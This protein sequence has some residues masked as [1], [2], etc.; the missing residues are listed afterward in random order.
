MRLFFAIPISDDAKNLI[1][2]SIREEAK[3]FN[4]K[5]VKKENLH[6]TLKFL[7]EVNKETVPEIEEKMEEISARHNSVPFKITNLGGFP[8]NDLLR[9]LFYNVTPIQPF[10]DLSEDI[11]KIMTKFGFKEEKNFLPHITIARFKTPFR[12]PLIDFE[13]SINFSQILTNLNL[14]ESKLYPDG[15]VYSIIKDFKLKGV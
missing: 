6:I 5:W 13:K 9:V 4:A 7:G 14:M 12:K 2:D 15:P 8:S 10:I 1:S 11:E 3:K